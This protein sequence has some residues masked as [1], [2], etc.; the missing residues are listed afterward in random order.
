[1]KNGL[2]SC[3]SLR[4]TPRTSTMRSYRPPSSKSLI[5]DFLS[6]CLLELELYW[7]DDSVCL[8][9]AFRLKRTFENYKLLI[10]MTSKQTHL[11]RSWNAPSGS[12]SSSSILFNLAAYKSISKLP[13]LPSFKRT[14]VNFQY[15]PGTSC[16]QMLSSNLFV[17]QAIPRWRN[18]GPPSAS[19]W[20][21]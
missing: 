11:R 15:V 18:G 14:F 20:E 3:I 13:D 17:E 12:S 1:M 8:N 2:L 4:T 7:F 16:L 9:S 6:T 19:R 5:D 21:V 10:T